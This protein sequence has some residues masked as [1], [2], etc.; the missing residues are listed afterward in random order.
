MK[1]CE[2]IR[3]R[4]TLYLDNELQGDERAA[5]E[6]HSSECE[7]CAAI[8]ARELNFLNAVRESGPLHIASPVL[9]EKIEAILNEGQ[10]LP[11]ALSVKATRQA[12]R[13]SWAVAI[14]AALL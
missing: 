12:S 8:F 10:V 11:A 2:D 14:A 1:N 13:F 7:S 3:G 5:V 6:T 9:R 4:L